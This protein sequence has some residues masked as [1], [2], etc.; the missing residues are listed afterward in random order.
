MK[1]LYLRRLCALATLLACLN[2]YATSAQPATQLQ[3][4]RLDLSG[5]LG[6]F[7]LLYG[8]DS[9]PAHLASVQQRVTQTDQLLSQLAEPTDGGGLNSLQQLRQQWPA[10]RT[11]L[12]ELAHSLQQQHSPSDGSIAELIQLNCLLTRL[13]D[14]LSAHYPPLA[15]PLALLQSI[16]RKWRYIEPSLQH[17][18]QDNVPTLVNRYSQRIIGDLQ[19]L[20]T[21]AQPSQ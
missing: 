5:S 13:S 17:Y 15:D 21:L 4:I 12:Q 8:V 7:Y 6:D 16:Q 2:S 1:H 14:T 10:Y 19:Q 3:Q 9:D 18:Q 20:P 11:L